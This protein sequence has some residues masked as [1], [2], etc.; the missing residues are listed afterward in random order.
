[1]GNITDATSPNKQLEPN[2]TMEQ[3]NAEKTW[4][5][6]NTTAQFQLQINLHYSKVIM[7]NCAIAHTL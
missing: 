4:L 7:Y 5:S 1:M 6:T 2:D 3:N